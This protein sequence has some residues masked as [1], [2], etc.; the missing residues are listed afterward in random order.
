M[1][2]TN[3]ELNSYLQEFLQEDYAKFLSMQAEPTAI[4]LNTLI[5][6]ADTLTKNLTRWQ[7]PFSPHPLNP[8]GYIIENDHLPL[9][10]SL[11]FF[12]GEF[13]YQGIA[14]QLPA[15]VLDPQPGETILDLA[16]SPGSKSTQIAALMKNQGRLFLN[17]VS[18]RRHQALV[19]NTL[20]SGI[21]NDV[22]IRMAGQRAG[23]LLPAYFDRVLVDA[24]C[25]A[26]GTMAKN[27][28]QI[29]NWWNLKVL[30]RLAN[31]QH[32]LLVSAVKAVKVNG[33]IVYSTCSIAPEE[34]EKNV[35]KLVKKYPLE[36]EDIYFSSHQLFQPGITSYRDQWFHPDITKTVR[37]H[38]HQNVIEGFFIAR[39]KKTDSIK[40]KYAGVPLNFQPTL[41]S[42]H[43]KVAWILEHLSQR[44]GIDI[45]Y[46]SRFRYGV[47]KNRL[48][49]LNNEW[50]EIPGEFL[51]KAGLMAAE[52]R[53][54]EWKLTNASV[55][56]FEEKITHSILELEKD[57]IKKLFKTG[58]LAH[59]FPTGY[60]I[61]KFDNR[62]IGSGSLFNG[63]LKIK[64]PHFFELVV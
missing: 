9:S 36:I 41:Q 20:R 8:T 40:N 13:F 53:Q 55:Q 25:S 17:E 52:K 42:D 63:I 50:D 11:P 4:R 5:A 1:K 38:H 24:P 43:P 37:T 64:L 51:T 3:Q 10:H 58:K 39:L 31:L 45:E 61:I 16:A 54:H 29:N 21:I 6:N 12:L 47:G 19:T 44:W 49:L 22:V 34:N 30:K 57:Q 7:V 35:T 23:T 33:I 32:Q 26:L 46:L 48:W 56:F 27:S 28:H 15:L 59:S 62:L 14:S 60:Y 18:L 2:P